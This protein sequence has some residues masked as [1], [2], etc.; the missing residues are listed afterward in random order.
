MAVIDIRTFPDPVLRKLAEPVENLTGEIVKLAE[1]MLETMILAHGAGLA[2]NQ[3]G[4]SR[5]IIVIDAT[6]NVRDNKPLI[7]LN[8]ILVD[9]DGE[10]TAEEGCLSLPGFYEF[11]KRAKKVHACGIDMNGNS[12]D[13]E[14]EGQFARAMQH[15]IDHLRGT[16]FID[17]L[18]PVKKGIF[19]KKYTGRK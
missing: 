7:L 9:T 15:E 12:I 19:K 14:C 16:L 18:G 6:L 5:Q 1:N 10:E 8:P 13:I 4:I 17:H 3:V 2:A 11:V